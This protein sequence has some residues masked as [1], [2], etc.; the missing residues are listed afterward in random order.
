MFLAH[1]SAYFELLNVRKWLWNPITDIFEMYRNSKIWYFQI[2]WFNVLKV[3]Y[4]RQM[5]A[6][7]SLMFAIVW[8]EWH[9][10]TN[11]HSRALWCEYTISNRRKSQKSVLCSFIHGLQV[12]YLVNPNQLHTTTVCNV[13]TVMTS[14][15]R[16]I[17]VA[18]Y[19]T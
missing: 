1:G 11:S 4:S 13:A 9:H 19:N 8:C 2:T 3:Y 18:S 6:K 7:C 17:I 15:C 5:Q 16:L 14:Y 12:T 10:S